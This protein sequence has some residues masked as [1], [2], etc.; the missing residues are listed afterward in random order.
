MCKICCSALNN[1]EMLIERVF[2]TKLSFEIQLELHNNVMKTESFDSS[3]KMIFTV[4]FR[5]QQG[6]L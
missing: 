6:N 1:S 2:I 4:N 5:L 3:L